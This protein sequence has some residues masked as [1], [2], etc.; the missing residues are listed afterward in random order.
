M[1][2]LKVFKNNL[3]EVCA[4]EESGQVLFDVDGVARSLGLVD[5]KNGIEYVRWTRVNSYLPKNSPEVAKGDLI[6]EPLVYK[7][8]F[9]ASNDVAEKFQ[10]WL[11]I[12]VI[13]TIRKTGSYQKPNNTKLLLQTALEHEKKIETIESDVSMLKE[14]MRIDGSEEFRIKR[15]A[16]RVVIE[17]LGGKKSNAYKSM[18]RKV[19]SRFWNEFKQYFEIPRYGDL[20]KKEYEKGINFIRSWQ[21]DTTTRLEIQELNNQQELDLDS[22]AS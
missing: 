21:P 14:T 13:P 19:F 17:S 18:G 5:K 8:A 15:N 10:D 22:D 4:K 6:P 9:K 20:P 3:F 1:N 11:A 12:D 16:N 7:L 2:E